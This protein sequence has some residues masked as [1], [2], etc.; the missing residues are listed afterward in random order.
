MKFGIYC[1]VSTEDQTLEQQKQP[2]VRRCESE[3]N[4]YRIYQEV[5]S[6]VKETRPQLDLMLQDMRKREIE[7]VMV[8]KLDRLGRSAVH[9]MQ[10]IA[11][12]NNKGV[13][14]VSITEG[15][16]TSTTMGRFCCTIMAAMAQ[17]ERENIS[18]RTKL[19]QAYLKSIGRHIGRPKGAKDKKPRRSAGYNLRWAGSRARNPRGKNPDAYKKDEK[20]INV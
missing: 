6:G 12:L 19:K 16:D 4:T 14:F 8:W 7:G 10:I 2:C 5:I 15:F 9:L 1:R 11:E 3:G 18:E 20:P 17:M 13:P